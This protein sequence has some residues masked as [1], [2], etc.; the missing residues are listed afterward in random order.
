MRFSLITGFVLLLATTEVV[1]STWFGKAGKLRLSL[2]N[3]V[4]QSLYGIFLDACA[5]KQLDLLE[6]LLVYNKWHETELERWLSD[7]GAFPCMSL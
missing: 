6:Y 3:T 4:C 7:H 5:L 1:G 2:A